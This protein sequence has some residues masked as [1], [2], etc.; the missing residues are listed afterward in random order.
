MEQ[1]SNLE[2]T[3]EQLIYAKIL[4]KGM[5]IGLVILFITFALYVF[6][7]M[8]PFIPLNEISQHWTKSVGT[9]LHDANIK[10]GWAWVG[11]LKYGDFI[12]FIGIALLAGVTIICYIA[13]V[14]GLLKSN[15][16]VYA[17]LAILE[18]VVLTIAASG[19]L[20]GGGH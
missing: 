20:G 5:L 19:I 3:P 10:E 6:G 14:P 15:D 17:V 11:M 4:E 2:A 9:Y 12:N 13:I 16:K 18:A 8:K 1:Q 7:I